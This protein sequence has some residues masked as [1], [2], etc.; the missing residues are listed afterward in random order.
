MSG[1]PGFGTNLCFLGF[2][3]ESLVSHVEPKRSRD[4]TSGRL[5]ER[6]TLKF[7]VIYFIGVYMVLVGTHWGRPRETGGP[8]L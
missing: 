1:G 6:S 3:G 4:P 8:H 2:W 7:I 5:M